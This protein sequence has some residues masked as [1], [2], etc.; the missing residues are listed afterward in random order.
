MTPSPCGRTC[1]GALILCLPESNARQVVCKWGD[2][3]VWGESPQTPAYEEENQSSSS[4]Q[5]K[6]KAHLNIS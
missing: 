4:Y 3:G 6:L 2:A 5:N 1:V